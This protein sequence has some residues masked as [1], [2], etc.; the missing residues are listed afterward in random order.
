M[1][2][3]DSNTGHLFGSVS[4]LNPWHWRSMHERTSLPKRAMCLVEIILAFR[5]TITVDVSHDMGQA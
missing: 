4:Y 1:A 2:T 3:Y 5:C